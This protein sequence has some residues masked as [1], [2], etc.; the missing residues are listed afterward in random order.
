MSAEDQEMSG[1]EAKVAV[2]DLLSA[3]DEVAQAQ[4]RLAEQDKA[5]AKLREQEEIEEKKEFEIEEAKMR[6]DHAEVVNRAQEAFVAEHGE[7]LAVSRNESDARRD[8]A[9]QF[10][11]EK[12][13]E[14]QLVQAQ[15]NLTFEQRLK[16]RQ[17]AFAERL[18]TKKNAREEEARKDAQRRQVLQ[19]EWDKAKAEWEKNNR[20]VLS[21]RQTEETEIKRKKAEFERQAAEYKLREDTEFKQYERA[22]REQQQIINNQWAIERARRQAEMNAIK[23]AL[24][25]KESAFRMAL[26]QRKIEADTAYRLTA[27]ADEREDRLFKRQEAALAL[28]SKIELA[29]QQLEFDQQMRRANQAQAQA[30]AQ[31][32][33][34]IQM[35]LA[36]AKQVFEERFKV[37]KLE[38]EQSLQTLREE[39]TRRRNRAIEEQKIRVL[40]MAQVDQRFKQ[41]LAQ[42]MQQLK[43]EA[44]KDK[45]R[46]AQARFDV[47]LELKREKIRLEQKRID[48]E[49]VTQQRELEY[50]KTMTEKKLELD[51]QYRRELAELQ[52]ERDQ[53]K[54]ELDRLNK[55]KDREAKRITDELALLAKREESQNKLGLAERKLAEETEFKKTV[56]D[57]KRQLEEI[58]LE[59]KRQQMA[60]DQLNAEK[61]REAKKLAQD[62]ALRLKQEETLVKLEL[63]RFKVEQDIELKKAQLESKKTERR[64]KK[65]RLEL[66]RSS[67]DGS[68]V[69]HV[70]GD[71]ETLLDPNRDETESLIGSDALT[72]KTSVDTKE[73]KA[74]EDF[75]SSLNKHL[76]SNRK[77]LLDA[78]GNSFV[79][80]TLGES[81]LNG[82]VK[83][84]ALQAID[85][86]TDYSRLIKYLGFAKMVYDLDISVDKEEFVKTLVQLAR[87]GLAPDLIRRVGLL[88]DQVG[89]NSVV[90]LLAD[91]ARSLSVARVA[92]DV[93]AG[94]AKLLADGQLS[95]ENLLESKTILDLRVRQERQIKDLEG[96][97][98]AEK[99]HSLMMNEYQQALDRLSDTDKKEAE[100]A[101]LVLRDANFLSRISLFRD[102]AIWMSQQTA[103]IKSPDELWAYIKR[104]SD[105]QSELALLK[106]QGD[107]DKTLRDLL[108]LLDDN[109]LQ[110]KQTLQLLR[111]LLSD[112]DTANLGDVAN[113]IQR[114]KQRNSELSL[115][116]RQ[117]LAA[118]GSL[119]QIFQSVSKQYA[120]RVLEFVRGLSSKVVDT[121]RA[122]GLP[123]DNSVA[124]LANKLT[125]TFAGNYYV[126]EVK[127]DQKNDFKTL[128]LAFSGQNLTNDAAFLHSASLFRWLDRFVVDP[129]RP[130][131]NDMA[132]LWDQAAELLFDWQETVIKTFSN[133]D[134]AG[135]GQAVSAAIVKG[136]LDAGNQFSLRVNDALGQTTRIA[137]S[138]LDR[139]GKDLAKQ[140]ERLN[141]RVQSLL[142]TPALGQ[143]VLTI[144]GQDTQTEEAARALFKSFIDATRTQLLD[145]N[146]DEVKSTEWVAKI[147]TLA[148]DM[149]RLKFEAN[150]KD[151][152]YK[153]LQSEHKALETKYD[154]LEKASDAS[155]KKIRDAESSLI[156]YAT[157]TGVTLKPGLDEDI[158][159]LLDFYEDTRQEFIKTR[160]LVS[161]LANKYQVSVP[162]GIVLLSAEMKAVLDIFAAKYDNWTAASQKLRALSAGKLFPG[163]HQPTADLEKDAEVVLNAFRQTLSDW[164]KVQKLVSNYSLLVFESNVN[165]TGVLEVDTK[166]ALDAYERYRQDFIALRDEENKWWTRVQDARFPVT[167]SLT[168]DERVEQKGANTLL[169]GTTGVLSL[170]AQRRDIVANWIGTLAKLIEENDHWNVKDLIAKAQGKP[171]S[172]SSASKPAAASAS[173]NPYYRVQFNGEVDTL[174][175]DHIFPVFLRQTPFMR[176]WMFAREFAGAAS[177]QLGNILEPLAPGLE[178]D[179][180][181]TLFILRQYQTDLKGKE[182]ANPPL[183]TGA[184][185]AEIARQE[186]A[187]EDKK[188]LKET[189]EARL[190]VQKDTAFDYIRQLDEYKN[191]SEYEI[192]VRQYFKNIALNAL[193]HCQ[194]M[195]QRT[196]LP[197]FRRITLA[198]LINSPNLSSGF[199]RM[200]GL[201]TLIKQGTVPG[202]IR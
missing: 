140:E 104:F 116:F 194:E 40:D 169:S 196:D 17:Q 42:Q 201:Y 44:E 63:A 6:S 34:Q 46:I 108:R 54:L 2:V 198:E 5:D 148:L 111:S 130:A 182:T 12:E 56:E 186:L 9:I 120:F 185:K 62:L 175:K 177:N 164:E 145:G 84:T 125:D 146:N 3:E 171:G 162:G 129:K 35:E 168:D 114:L 23:E 152:E 64:K 181:R 96:Q 94:V 144:N 165:A 22:S 159:R 8:Q 58:K 52:R 161:V 53:R 59:M 75:Y 68:D 33:Q 19:M 76:Y 134:V 43:A 39:E 67:S 184:N 123:A 80:L 158:K 139:F 41:Q 192:K 66:K 81:V 109:L 47:E 92:P 83:K 156:T 141:R 45:Q 149:S 143:Y 151:S 27:Y 102:M 36:R 112:P 190:K 121:T 85:T 157:K 88:V 14:W 167:R 7:A 173:A 119:L 128:E 191:L 178:I 155:T 107:V 29:Q 55:E 142:V 30:S 187:S 199:A 99:K 150:V 98:E 87:T 1:A 193:V 86:L 202:M 174:T 20:D 95:P 49:Q 163:G 135:Q 91:I 183:P 101:I 77:E 32:K 100:A 176:L 138:A 51:E 26:A 106:K 195:L 60:M 179:D 10:I 115:S 57:R 82:T 154:A 113:T 136:L 170:L 93:V 127:A 133:T 13:R 126:V 189:A 74:L 28:R 124:Q 73:F 89:D 4:Q 118:M 105:V 79:R 18:A 50:K 21:Q 160:G 180:E 147:D 97:L 132:K 122:W 38:H 153:K 110:P 137:Q 197:E 11:A 200:C 25:E 37:S 103:P 188:D 90:P 31:Q 24:A 61:D 131:D 48:M 166:A 78:R 65:G 172:S 72:D 69:D 70:M 15:A 71:G 16:L 117:T